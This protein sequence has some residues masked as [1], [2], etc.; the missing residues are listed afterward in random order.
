MWNS[1]SPINTSKYRQIWNNPHGNLTGNW[2]KDSNTTK[3]VRKEAHNWVAQYEKHWV[4]T[5]ANGRGLGGKR[6]L[7]GWT[8]ALGSERVK[9][10]TGFPNPGVLCLGDKNAWLLGQKGWRS[11]ESTHEECVG[12]GMIPGR[13]KSGLPKQLLPHRIPSL[14]QVNAPVML[15]PCH[16]LELDLGWPGCGEKIDLGMQR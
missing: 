1:H 5:C 11:L 13:V 10:Q 12:T 2:Q 4:R 6:R 9:P 16:S 8:L 3:A 15:T 7:Q 14:S